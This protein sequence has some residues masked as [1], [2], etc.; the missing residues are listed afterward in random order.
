ME[1]GAVG[2][3]ERKVGLANARAG[4]VAAGDGLVSQADLEEIAIGAARAA[5]DA[6]GDDVALGLV[7]DRPASGGRRLRESGRG[8]RQKASNQR[9]AFHNGATPETVSGSVAG[10]GPVGGPSRINR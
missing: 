5:A 3:G 6:L 9:G 7:G 8:E 1:A 2:G 10:G 4:E